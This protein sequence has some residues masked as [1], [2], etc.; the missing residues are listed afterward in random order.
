MHIKP[1]SDY[2]M[3]TVDIQNGEYIKILNEG[4]YSQSPNNPDK[5]L[6]TIRVELPNG[7]AKKL[8]VNSTSQK[9]ILMAWK[10]ESKD[11]VGKKCRV[12][13]I[14]QKVFD[15]MKDVIYLHP[16]NGVST[17]KAEKIPDEEFEELLPEE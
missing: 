9:E 5:E 1:P 6:L 3:P 7:E 4:V 8:T 11:W 12:E 14:R 2:V 13:I 10:D 17:I 16:E 15:K